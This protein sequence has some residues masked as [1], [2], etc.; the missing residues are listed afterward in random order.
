MAPKSSPSK[1]TLATASAT[2]ATF[3]VA[4]FFIADVS[5]LG[6][7]RWSAV[8]SNLAGSPLNRSSQPGAP[9]TEAL[10]PQASIPFTSTSGAR[11][12]ERR[13]RAA[14]SSARRSIN[15]R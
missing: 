1:V 12:F 15:V 6:L 10:L 3:G 9:I 11:S 13:V 5:R 4:L 2:V 7:L 8:L 14:T